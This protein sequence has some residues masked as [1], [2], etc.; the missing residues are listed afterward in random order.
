MNRLFIDGKSYQFTKP[1][2]KKRMIGQNEESGSFLKSTTA[3]LSKKEQFKTLH[4]DYDL[5]G[6]ETTLV[7]FIH[8]NSLH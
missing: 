4:K 1:K 5:A 3:C 7:V 6:L 2:K 8:R